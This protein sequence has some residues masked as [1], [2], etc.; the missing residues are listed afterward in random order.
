MNRF[1]TLN[2]LT[3]G[4]FCQKAF[5]GTF[6]WF[7]GCISAKLALIW[8]KRHLQHNSLPFLPLASRFTTFGLGHAQKS[9]FWDFWIVFC[10]SFPFS[11]FLLFLLQRLAFYWACLQ[12]KRFQQSLTRQANLTMKVA[13]CS[14][15]EFFTQLF[16]RRPKL[17]ARDSCLRAVLYY[18]RIY[19]GLYGMSTVFF[20]R[21]ENVMFSKKKIDLPYCLVVFF[22]VCPRLRPFWSV[23]GELACFWCSTAI[24]IKTRQHRDFRSVQE[25]PSLEANNSA[26]KFTFINSVDKPNFRF[27]V[28]RFQT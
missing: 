4:A 12:S 5:F 22:V 24:K 1:K 15:S 28:L 25:C 11:P 18:K 16:H 8:S 10:F 14:G 7:S 23:F 21:R 13:M 27:W 19:K 6:W 9:K 2:P 20:K 3:P 26:G 17:T